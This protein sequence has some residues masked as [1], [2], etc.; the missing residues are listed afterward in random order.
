MSVAIDEV[1]VIEHPPEEVVKTSMLLVLAGFALLGAVVLLALFAWAS[2][3]ERNGQPDVFGM[4]VTVHEVAERYKA[5]WS[6]GVFWPR[7]AFMHTKKSEVGSPLYKIA[8]TFL[9]AWFVCVAFYLIF[10]GSISAI[11]VFREKAHLHAAM[12]V[13]AALCLCAVWPVLFRIGSRS[14]LHP[15]PAE[16]EGAATSAVV[17]AAATTATKPTAPLAVSTHSTTKETFLWISFVV[18]LIAAVFAVVGSALIQAW[19]LPGPQFGTL[20]FL[21]PGYGLFAGWLLF[22]AA[23]NLRV[24]ISYNS[25]PSGTLPWPETR[26]EYTHRGS[27]WPPALALVIA[28]IAVLIP[29]PAIPLPALIA[30]FLF[31]PR[32][33]SHLA[34][35]A[36]CL[37]GFVVA[38]VLVV[39]KRS[40]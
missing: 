39:W 10:A 23:L 21:G 7:D 25:Y 11:E 19:T 40:N 18:L 29:D 4:R 16:E 20:I 30:L 12:C 38:T 14:E 32:K 24:A 2:Q 37:L 28:C 6:P 35:S 26:T 3:G 9:V 27:L 22:A 34:A 17:A 1:V 13:A 8:W 31:T 15:D 33:T 5:A 36:I